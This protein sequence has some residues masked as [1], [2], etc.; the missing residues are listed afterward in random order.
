MAMDAGAHAWPGEPFFSLAHA[1]IGKVLPDA[2]KGQ[3]SIESALE[4]ASHAYLLAAQE[5]GFLA[6]NL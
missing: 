2:L 1:E 5:K 3:R 4:G 6:K